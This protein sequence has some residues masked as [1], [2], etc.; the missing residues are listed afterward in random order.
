MQDLNPEEGKRLQEK[1]VPV[2]VSYHSRIYAIE[3][4]IPDLG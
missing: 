1:S 2:Q 4:T 3:S